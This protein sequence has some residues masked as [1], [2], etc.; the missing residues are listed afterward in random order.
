MSAIGLRESD[1]ATLLERKRV[2]D[3]L[4]LA[5]LTLVLGALM[6]PWWLGVAE[7]PFPT[8]ARNTLVFGTFFAT[9][10]WAAD[11]LTQPASVLASIYGLHGLG[12]AFSAYLWASAGGLGNPGLLSVFSIGVVASGLVMVRWLPFQYALLSV[13]C[14]WSLS[15]AQSGELQWF[16]MRLGLP[17]GLVGA[18]SRL[19]APE[20]QRAFTASTTA[21]QFQ[22]T[23]LVLFSG[24]Q[25]ALALTS[26]ALADSIERLNHRVRSYRDRS[27][28]VTGIFEALLRASTSPT[29]VAYSDSL[30][31]VHASDSFVKRMLLDPD[32]IPGKRLLDLVRF[33]SAEEVE[34]SLQ[35]AKGTIPLQ[36]IEIGPERVVVNLHFY[37]TSHER[38]RYLTLQFEEITDLYYF[39]AAF[40][41]VADAVLIIDQENRLLFANRVAKRLFG[42]LYLGQE[43]RSL[44]R[45]R[46]VMDPETGGGMSRRVT[47]EDVPY[48]LTVSQTNLVGDAG[49]CKILWLKSLEESEALRAAAI[50]DPLT[51][52]YNRR[53]FDE[54]FS[55]LVD[56]AS[57]SQPLTLCIFDL[58]HFKEVNDQHGHQAGDAYLK[59]FTTLASG[60]LR[61]GDIFARLGGDEFVMALPG[62]S[63]ENALRVLDRVYAGL[64]LQP[65]LLDGQQQEVATSAGVAGCHP[66][67]TPEQLFERAD[68]ALYAAKQAGRNRYEV[69]E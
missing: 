16:L 36:R 40:E 13:A 11:R 17:A 44:L 24:V 63:L 52:V 15:V 3:S 9:V 35:N 50:R 22:I 30:Q 28:E 10:A 8:L 14:V 60:F 21:P 32:T 19:P 45:S 56:G 42:D 23:L 37:H 48:H 4:W 64:E 54:Y 34:S 55:I 29:L 33:E 61:S 53:Y 43:M 12:I 67:E 20:L 5:H 66:G 68:R 18:L 69:A 26:S 59:H 25:V 6:V 41:S 39:H 27:R 65:V 46:R 57:R 1:L 2:L 58:D 47:L 7:L 38:N 31:V 62:T 49:V 51:G